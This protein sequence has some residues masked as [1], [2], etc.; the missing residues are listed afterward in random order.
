MALNIIT[1]GFFSIVLM[2]MC[3]AK[4]CFT[5][6]NVGNYGKDNDP[7]IFNN[8]DIG[9]AFNA[10]EMNIQVQQLSMEMNFSM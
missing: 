3:D 4:Y 8:S 2:A 10:N 5:F 6:V 9:K 7:Q 1:I